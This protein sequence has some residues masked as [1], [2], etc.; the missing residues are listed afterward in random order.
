MVSSEEDLSFLRQN[1]D[2]DEGS[3]HKFMISRLY[4]TH[5]AGKGVSL[6]GPMIGAP[7]AVMILERLIALGAKKII[8]WGWC[9]SLQEQVKISDFV[10][11]IEA[12]S[13]EGTSQ[14]YLPDHPLSKPHPGMIEV[15][16]GC[17]M[18]H[19]IPFH[20]G[21]IWTTDAPFRET[22]EKVL[23]FKREG[24]LAVEMEVSA[25]FTVSRFRGVALGALLVVSDE[26]ATLRWKHGFSLAGFANARK[27][28]AKVIG[29]LCQ[30]LLQKH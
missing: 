8:F 13:E 6:V 11:P 1:M 7:Y 4:Q 18:S 14:H 21:A 10:I 15:I 23:S 19:R 2:I 16:E 9:G 25:L 24:K 30:K 22:K 17:L 5:S 29:E 28:A 26:L 20:K 27:A 12:M 3:F